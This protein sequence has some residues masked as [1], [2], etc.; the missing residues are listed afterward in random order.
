MEGSTDMHAIL[1]EDA[2]DMH[3]VMYVS[4]AACHVY[5]QVC[6]LVIVSSD[7]PSLSMQSDIEWS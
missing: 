2:V 6:M 3:V 1:R 4:H 7:I 5:Q